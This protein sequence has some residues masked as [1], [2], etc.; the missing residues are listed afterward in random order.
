M[1]QPT[2]N[3]TNA[4]CEPFGGS[5]LPNKRKNSTTLLQPVWNSL[6]SKDSTARRTLDTDSY[7]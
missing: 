5:W 1:I 6:P 3:A 4:S 7:I 2:T